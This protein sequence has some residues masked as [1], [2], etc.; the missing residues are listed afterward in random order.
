MNPLRGALAHYGIELRETIGPDFGEVR[1]IAYAEP[2]FGGISRAKWLT[3]HVRALAQARRLRKPG[4]QIIVLWP[5]L[6][7]FDV[8]LLK[9]IC[10]RGALI[11]HDPTPLVRAVGYGSG[12]KAVARLFGRGVTVIAHSK[13]AL[14]EVTR[15]LPA[16]RVGQVLHPIRF[17]AAVVG[18]E[19]NARPRIAV[20]GQYKSERDSELL[21]EL[22]KQMHDAV[23]LRIAG[24]GWP[25]LPGWDVEARFLSE[26]EFTREIGDANVVLIPYRRF[27]QSGVAVRALE[28]GVPVVGP[29]SSALADLLGDAKSLLA[30]DSVESWVRAVRAALQ[31]SA[32]DVAALR[33]EYR[34]R[35]R[36][37][38]SD[39]IGQRR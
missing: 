10:G 23:D 21:L 28:N 36:E 33:T 32:E 8:L 3:N 16:N 12:A 5:V 9:A 39:L 20:L 4:G 34:T 11:M 6:G 25:E 13:R 2:S 29:R 30:A 22:A 35:S 27:Y 37:S 17:G 15:T 7:F 19:R 18:P 1:E 38:W 31:M 26:A 14:E 24:K